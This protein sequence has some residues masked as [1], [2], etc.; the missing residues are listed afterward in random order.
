M[1]KLLARFFALFFTIEEPKHNKYY[2]SYREPG[3]DYTEQ[4]IT[5]KIKK[6]NVWLKNFKEKVSKMSYGDFLK[7]CCRTLLVISLAVLAGGGSFLLYKVIF[8]DG[9]VNYC[10]IER[11]TYV[12]ERT[13][14]EIKPPPDPNSIVGKDDPK[15]II[16]DKEQTIVIVYELKGH[17]DWRDNRDIGRFDRFEDAIEASHKINCAVEAK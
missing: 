8:A 11:W 12:K 13:I 17:R 15:N 3:S 16:P 5:E 2:E 1:S 7:N 4:A 9:N 10:Y 14:G 6:E